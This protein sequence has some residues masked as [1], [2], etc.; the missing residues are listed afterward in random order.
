MACTRAVGSW[1]PLCMS[2]EWREQ[3][4]CAMNVTHTHKHYCSAA[5]LLLSAHLSC[6]SSGVLQLQL[7]KELLEAGHL[8]CT[9]AHW[10]KSVLEARG[11]RDAM[12]S[13]I[14]ITSGLKT[15]CFTLSLAA[16]KAILS[17]VCVFSLSHLSV[18]QLTSCVASLFVVEVCCRARLSEQSTLE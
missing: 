17:I 10:R 18:A 16:D 14:W 6:G 9:S 7:G 5:M 12:Q 1:G 13:P 8:F 4:C 3:A 15:S 11:V 2:G